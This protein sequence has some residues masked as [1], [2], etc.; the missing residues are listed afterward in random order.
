MSTTFSASMWLTV[1]EVRE[2]LRVSKGCVYALIR[3][4]AL[5]AL[6]VGRRVRVARPVFEAFI[7]A[8]GSR[9][10]PVVAEERIS[11]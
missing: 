4:G 2:V 1:D 10:R 8:G 3:V 5:P 6:H 11:G 9:K 7:A